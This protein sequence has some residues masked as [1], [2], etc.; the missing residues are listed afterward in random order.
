MLKSI[1]LIFQI[2]AIDIKRIKYKIGL[3]DEDN[4]EKINVSVKKLLFL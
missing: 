1:A 3:L 2:R 4:L